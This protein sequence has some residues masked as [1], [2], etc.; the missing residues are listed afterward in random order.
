[1]YTPDLTP[2]GIETLAAELVHEIKK[3]DLTPW[4]IETDSEALNQLLRPRLPDLTPWGIETK[5][6]RHIDRCSVVARPY[7]LGNCG[8]WDS[9][10][11]PQHNAGSNSSFP[12]PLNA[13]V[14]RFEPNERQLGG[15]CFVPCGAE[16]WCVVP[17]ANV[18]HF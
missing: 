1:M 2:W 18:Q 8:T 12:V 7:P 13:M 3:P 15:T 17:I 10:F 6:D 5:L 16:D 4:G 9:V 14:E 11:V